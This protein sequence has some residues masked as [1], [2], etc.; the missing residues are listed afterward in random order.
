L[1]ERETAGTDALYKWIYA[2]H[3][4][5][6]VFVSG[7]L[8]RNYRGTPRQSIGLVTSLLVPYVITSTLMAL[9]RALRGS[10]FSLNLFKPSFAMWYLLA[11]FA[12]RLMVPVLRVVPFALPLSVLVSVASVTYHGVSQDVS[13]ARILSFLPFFTAGLLL[14]PGHLARFRRITDPLRVRALCVVVLLAMLAVAWRV[15]AHIKTPWLYMYGAVDKYH[16]SNAENIGVRLAVLAVAATMTAALLAAVPRR[17]TPLTILGI[18][19]MYVYLS[20][21][22]I[23]DLLRNRIGAHEWTRPQS[24]LL[25]LGGAVLA[26]VLATP[27]IRRV[28]AWL[29]DPFG[30]IPALRA[31][32]ERRSARLDPPV[33]QAVPG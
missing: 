26:V 19:S 31:W 25:I 16:L 33:A 20:H 15:H 8:S 29:F 14:T 17:R 23:V 4:P 12:W 22:L 3:M 2:F 27:L 11:L 21:A 28:T 32:I 18:N 9:E 10:T 30:N 5:A 7:Y 6:F 1:I 24:V 13:G